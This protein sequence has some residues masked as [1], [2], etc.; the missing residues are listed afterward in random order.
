[1]AVAATAW[2]LSKLLMAVP[3]IRMSKIERVDEAIQTVNFELSKEEVDSIDPLY[4]PK[5]VIGISEIRN[6]QSQGANL[7][8]VLHK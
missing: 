3:I 2:S 6:H 5:N 8:S 1:M 4:E 7:V